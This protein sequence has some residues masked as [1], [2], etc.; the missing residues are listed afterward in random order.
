M[1]RW[2]PQIPLDEIDGLPVWKPETLL[3]FMGARPSSF[4]WEYIAEWLWEA[5][6]SLDEHLL[7]SVLE[8][9]SWAAWMK[10]AY[11]IET[12]ER[13]DVAETL[14][15]LAPSNTKGPRSRL[16]ALSGECVSPL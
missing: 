1:C 9:R 4:P 2:A 5:C 10:T 13:P 14:L 16:E 7:L 8:S 11:L 6:E 3:V 12:G 15:R